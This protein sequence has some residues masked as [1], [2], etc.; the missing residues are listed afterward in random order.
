MEYL[1][2]FCKF[3]SCN[4]PILMII[5]GCFFL[6]APPFFS[7]I[8]I[9]YILSVW[10]WPFCFLYYAHF[11]QKSYAQAVLLAFL[12]VGLSIRFHG[13]LGPDFE[14]AGGLFMVFTSCVFWIPF[15]WDSVYCHKESPFLYT[16]IFPAIF[17]TMNYILSACSV[18]PICSLAYAQYDNKPFLQLASVIGEFGLTFLITWAASIAVYVIEHWK[19]PEGKRAGLIALSVLILLHVGG[20]VCYSTWH[21]DQSTVKVA[22][23]I[24]PKLDQDKSEW[25]ILTY[26]RNVESFEKIAIAAF[27]KGADILVF[28]EEAFTIEDLNEQ[29]FME[30]VREMARKFSLPVLLTLEVV[31]MDNNQEGKLINKAILVDKYGE[32]LAEYLKHNI[33]P[34][35]EVG[36]TVVGEGPIPAKVL[37]L[38]NSSYAV[39]F[40]ICYD[41]NFSE[42]VRGMDPTT[43]LYFNPCWDW[44]SINDYH[45]RTIGVRSV[46]MGVNLVM[47][48]NDGMS[49]VSNSVGKEVSLAQIDQ[50]GL[51]Q[52]LIT[53]VPTKQTET[54]YSKIGGLLNLIYPV[55]S[56]VFIVFGQRRGWR[57]KIKL[58]KLKRQRTKE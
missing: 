19:K 31:D 16:L 51:D 56:L 26:E 36:S 6:L 18:I 39:S 10:I 44:K 28:S 22:Q 41:G 43:Q 1:K 54:V 34:V 49:L 40:T 50:L 12:V 33:L 46:E 20:A 37:A 5:L 47:T 52:I 53:E 29:R 4:K 2:R 23:A 17:C 38:G 24:G 8:K 55:I 13:V 9:L 25:G 27:E 57:R 21:E 45:Y 30:H 14:G 11:S 58:N 3:L 32:V 15:V 42:F 35:V 48:T 7:N